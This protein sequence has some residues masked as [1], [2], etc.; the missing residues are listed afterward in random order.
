MPLIFVTGTSTSGKSTIVNEL[1]KLGYEAHDTEREGISAW[2]NKKTGARV[3]E[4]NNIPDRTKEWY[5]SHDW[6]ISVDKVKHF[7]GKAKS[8][9]IFICGNAANE[10]DVQTYCSK[11]IWLKIDEKSIRRRF[12]I[13]REHDWGK[14]EYEIDMAINYNKKAEPKYRKSGAILIDSTEP[15]DEVVSNVIRSIN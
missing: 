9:T 5:E 14:V 11:V 7:A 3:A 4:F 6:I 12:K 2:Y 8:K 10:L 1:I 15:I 13:P